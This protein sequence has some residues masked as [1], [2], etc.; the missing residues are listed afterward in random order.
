MRRLER[1]LTEG[2]PRLQ[3]FAEVTADLAR[4]EDQGA[5]VAR[6]RSDAVS[7][8]AYDPG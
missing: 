4:S 1:Y 6:P 5:D 8:T 3:Y 7:V 2:T